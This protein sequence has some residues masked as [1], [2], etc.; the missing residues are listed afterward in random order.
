ML[1]YTIYVKN[2]ENG[3]GYID[4]PLEDDQLLRDYQQFLDVGLRPHK[5]YPLAKVPGSGGTG[6][7]TINV[8]EVAAMTVTPPQRSK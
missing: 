5:L 1:Y 3:T 2:L 6:Y 8:E 7:F 4:I